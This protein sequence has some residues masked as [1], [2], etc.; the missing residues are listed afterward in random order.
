MEGDFSGLKLRR[1]Y[2]E[3]LRCMTVANQ[4]KGPILI[5]FHVWK[6][7]ETGVAE[8]SVKM[9]RRGMI[10]CALV[11]M[12]LVGSGW[13][14][15]QTTPSQQAQPGPRMMCSDRFDAL[16]ANHDGVVTKEEFMAAGHG[17][18]RPEEVFKSRDANN[19]GQ[20]TRDEFCAGKGK[21][22]GGMGQGKTTR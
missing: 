13:V 14:A 5:L 22:Q 11:F 17:G 19:D 18:G 10:I 21:G 8:R 20:L 1:R 9:S 16:D 15:A 12:V 3:E 7:L 6:I 2:K 4:E